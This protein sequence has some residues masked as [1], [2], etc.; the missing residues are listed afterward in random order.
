MRKDELTL[1]ICY[2]AAVAGL[3]WTLHIIGNYYI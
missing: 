2:L 3:L 1:A